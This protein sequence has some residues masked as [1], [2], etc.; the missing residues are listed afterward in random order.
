[1]DIHKTAIINPGADLGDE[2]SVGPYAI[3]NDK[4]RIGS[5][6]RIGPHCVIESFTTIGK[7]CQIFSGAIIGSITQDKKFKGTRSFL[8]IGD[9]NIIREYA[10]INR[11]TEEDSKTIIGNDNLIMAYSHIAHDCR[12]GNE[13]VIANCGT[14]A[15]YVTIE[16][17]AVLGGLSAVHQ[18][19]RM[20]EL[21]IIGGCSKVVQDIVPYSMADG[22]PAEV[23][24]INSLGLERADIQDEIRNNLKKAFKMLFSM[25]LNVKNALAR[26]EEEIPPSREINH[27]IDFIKSSQ[28]GISR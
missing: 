24:G 3:I 12:I 17:K 2:V 1:M 7:N 19:V 9:N 28:R 8:E 16:D 18:Y 25:K 26:I 13:V 5:G 6:T 11:G 22:H 10:T 4:V 14:L 23:Y 27:L 20:G 15:G 21:A